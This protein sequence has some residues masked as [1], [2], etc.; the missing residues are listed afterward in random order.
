MLNLHFI[1]ELWVEFDIV[2][3][4]SLQAALL[5][6]QMPVDLIGEKMEDDRFYD[7]VNVIL[8][9]QVWFSLI[10]KHHAIFNC[11]FDFVTNYI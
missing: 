11:N 5:L 2:Q 9:L 1:D 7:A 10:K 3:T 8:S 4:H 6:S